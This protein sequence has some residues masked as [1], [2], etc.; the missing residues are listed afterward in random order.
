MGHPDYILLFTC[1]Y[2]HNNPN[3]ELIGKLNFRSEHHNMVDVTSGAGRASTV[4]ADPKRL[5]LRVLDVASSNLIDMELPRVFNIDLIFSKTE[6]AI[7]TKA[8]LDD[9]KD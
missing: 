9:Q 7:K 1:D 3:K 8:F 6:D 2:D 4:T 5:S